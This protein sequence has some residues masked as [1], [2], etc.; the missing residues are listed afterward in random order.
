MGIV[1]IPY[2]SLHGNRILTKTHDLRYT[3]FIFAK[4]LR[5]FLI[6][7]F[8][9]QLLC[10]G[11]AC[12]DNLIDCLICNCTGNC[13]TDP[14]CRICG[15]LKS[16]FVLKLIDCFHQAD[17]PLLNQIQKRQSPADILL[18]NTYYQSEIGFNQFLLGFRIT[19]TDPL[20]NLLL[21]FHG[22]EI[23]LDIFLGIFLNIIINIQ[24]NLTFFQFFVIHLI[25][26]FL[27]CRQRNRLLHVIF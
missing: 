6:G 14:P 8:S 26:F 23:F 16:F 17:I 13:L 3:I 24:K 12:T 19:L 10:Q 1:L 5:N 7:R 20:G 9:S 2:R 4:H 18:G 25:R 22:R 15:K 11:T 21:F 27:L